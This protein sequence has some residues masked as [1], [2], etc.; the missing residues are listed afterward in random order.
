[1]NSDT[2]ILAE[3]KSV[4]KDIAE[5]L[6]IVSVQPTHFEVKG[7][8]KV[9]Y[10]QG[11]LVEIAAPEALNPAWG[12]RWHW[13]Q[14]PMIPE[15][16]SY[17][18][19]DRTKK[20]L[21]DIQV[22]L[23]KAKTVIIATDAGREGELIAR[24][25]LHYSKWR[26]EV[27]RFWTSALMPE[28]IKHALNNLL[29]GA[30]KDNLYEAA[31]ARSHLDNVF[32]YTGSRAATLAANVFKNHFPVGR[33]QTPVL[34]LVVQRTLQNQ[35]FASS[36]YYTIEANV[37]TSGGHHLNMKHQLP[38]GEKFVKRSEAE[39]VCNRL[40]ALPGGPT[41]P[42]KQT[43]SA[44]VAKAPLAFSLPKLQQAANRVFAFSSKR[45]LEIAQSLY[46]GKF[47]TYPR[48]DSEHLATSQIP[49]MEPTLDAIA[50]IFP[51]EVA[52]LRAM[53]VLFR[54]TTFDNTKLGDH[55]GIVPTTNSPHTLSGEQAQLYRL[56]A[57]QLLQVLAPDNEYD[58]VKISMVVDGEEFAAKA[59]QDKVAGWTEFRTLR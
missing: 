14:L 9:C 37:K 31:L 27:K 36:F 35:G 55:H 50:A 5:V 13:G 11:H 51:S 28:D 10:A 26:G 18:P 40:L 2:L 21:K 15:Q 23:K 1:M 33:V 44:K 24:E 49:S 54:P 43:S 7:G 58:S 52:R 3:K 32:G 48:T 57:A 20:L 34:G 56:I 42:L 29:P 22:L 53:G 41:A 30:A 8:A 16:W 45:T 25:I 38:K 4:A 6:G 46:E 17:V 47:I 59:K 39:A 12:G 19:V